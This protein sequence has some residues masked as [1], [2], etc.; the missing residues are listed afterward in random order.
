MAAHS[1]VW[2]RCLQ[3]KPHKREEP[4]WPPAPTSALVPVLVSRL[5]LLLY[6]TSIKGD[7]YILKG[8][9][10]WMNHYFPSLIRPRAAI[11][12]P[13]GDSDV[14]KV[15]GVSSS[16]TRF[17]S[18]ARECAAARWRLLIYTQFLQPIR[19]A[20]PYRQ[21]LSRSCAKVTLMVTACWQQDWPKSTCPIV[22][23][24]HARPC[25]TQP[26]DGVFGAPGTCPPAV[27]HVDSSP[28]SLPWP[29][30]SST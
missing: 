10:I 17:Y 9:F 2:S 27:T 1:W 14:N 16:L 15:R 13:Y 22:V 5:L 24:P 26:I 11:R 12:L 29:P 4:V 8:H 21:M 6:I 23:I 25:L 28:P 18:F 19:A 20:A 30:F 7:L 3:N